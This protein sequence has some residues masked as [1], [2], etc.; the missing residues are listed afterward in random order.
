MFHPRLCK[1]VFATSMFTHTHTYTHTH[2]HQ[3]ISTY[4]EQG[5]KSYR[6]PWCC[7]NIEKKQIEKTTTQEIA[8][9]MSP[10]CFSTFL[11]PHLI[12]YMPSNHQTINTALKTC[13]KD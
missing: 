9:D 8:Q 10:V 12:V 6:S 2:T 4:S 11:H 7:H 5:V 1:S 13:I 3:L